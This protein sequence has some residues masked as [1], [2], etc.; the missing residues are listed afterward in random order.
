MRVPRALVRVLDDPYDVILSESIVG[1]ADPE[2]IHRELCAFC[3]AHLESELVDVPFWTASV[4]AG[5]GL[6]LRDGRHLFL[7]AWSG[8]DSGEK[9]DAV[10][11]V[12]HALAE[13][14]FPAPRVLV[15]PAPFIAGRA[16]VMEWMDRG[17]QRDARDPVLRR[18]MAASLARM[19]ELAQPFVDL[20]GLPRHGYPPGR[21]WGPTHN[22]L[23]DFQATAAGAEWIDDI[24]L[25]AADAA[26]AGE[27]R[28]VLGHRDWRVQNMRF[29]GGRVSAVYDWDSLTVA[30]EPEIVAMAAAT[31]TRTTSIQ[32]ERSLPTPAQMAAFVADYEAAAGRRFTAGEWR[33]AGA[34]AT[35]LLAYT[36]RCEHCHGPRTEPDSAQ[37]ILRGHARET[38]N[39]LACFGPAGEREDG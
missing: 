20:P 13:Q 15:R 30:L 36:A 32:V 21:D 31:Y 4:G 9:L 18:A 10:H 35:H 11:T 17:T 14:G 28:R 19:V 26:R 12:Q 1:T 24:A 5:F 37:G 29:A 39:V 34:A 23:F 2:A 8:T 38:S 25:A 16:S 33:T 3:A 7:K 27:G 6:I 22:A